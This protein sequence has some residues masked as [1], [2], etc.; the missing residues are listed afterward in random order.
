MKEQ[1]VQII[2]LTAPSIITILSMIGIVIKVILN[3]RALKKDVV[4]MKDLAEVKLLL[5][6]VVKEN[7]ELKKTLNKTMSMID[8]IDRRELINGREKK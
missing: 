8:H 4:D 3:F 1:I 7:A 6:E 2:L 5:R